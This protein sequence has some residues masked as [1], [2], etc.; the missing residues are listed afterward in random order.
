MYIY[1]Y[2]YYIS[3]PYV[4]EVLACAYEIWRHALEGERGKLIL[5]A[6]DSRVAVGCIA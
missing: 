3:Y 1:I 4:K 5:V 2:I 6:L